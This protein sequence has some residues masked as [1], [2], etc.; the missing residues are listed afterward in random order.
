MSRPVSLTRYGFAPSS[1]AARLL[2]PDGLRLWNAER[3]AP[4]DDR[5]AALLDALA[6]AADPDLA[7]HQLHRLVEAE[8]REAARAARTGP[9]AARSATGPTAKRSTGQ[10]A[11]PAAT[12]TA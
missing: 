2:G 7:L 10:A 9:G 4:V 5:A 8:R 12:R 1:Q 3:Q 6:A 11:I